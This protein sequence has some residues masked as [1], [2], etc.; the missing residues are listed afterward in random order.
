MQSVHSNHKGNPEQAQH[1]R[2]CHEKHAETVLTIFLSLLKARVNQGL[3]INDQSLLT[4]DPG[5]WNNRKINMANLIGT[6]HPSGRG[7]FTLCQS[8]KGGNFKLCLSFQI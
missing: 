7:F 3:F 1:P 5:F 2:E 8:L 6:L 4:I